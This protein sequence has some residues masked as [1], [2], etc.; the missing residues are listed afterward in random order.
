MSL[1]LEEKE[2]SLPSFLKF[3]STK[4]GLGLFAKKTLRANKK[5]GLY[6]ENKEENT[7]VC[8]IGN[9]FIDAKDHWTG[10]INHSILK[11]NCVLEKNGTLR[12][13]KN[14]KAENNFYGIMVL[15]IGYT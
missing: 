1:K 5:L 15:D 13:T 11:T 8:E 7:Y 10:Y 12:T 3:E 2:K 6:P 9:K 4:F 14:I